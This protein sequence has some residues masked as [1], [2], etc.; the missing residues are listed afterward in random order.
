MISEFLKYEDGSILFGHQYHFGYNKDNTRYTG[1][2]K[3]TMLPVKGGEFVMGNNQQDYDETAKPEHRVV[4]DD[5]YIMERPVSSALQY[6]MLFQEYNFED[7]DNGATAEEIRASFSND[8]YGNI[9]ELE[10]FIIWLNKFYSTELDELCDGWRFRLPT[11]AEWEY[12]ARALG[13]RVPIQIYGDI[14]SNID[15][16]LSKIELNPS[17]IPYMDDYAVRNKI[18]L[19]DMIRYAD[20]LCMDVYESNFYSKFATQTI[21]NPLAIGTSSG[22]TFNNVIRGGDINAGRISCNEYYRKA[23]EYPAFTY[24]TRLVLANPHMQFNI[25]KD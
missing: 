6:E 24:S 1:Q 20:E 3:F 7:F 4:L 22:V 25:I 13:R 12:S 17:D 18:G 21:K 9:L 14:V 23:L 8:Q 15:E 5:F 2:G 19:C 16:Y 11:E 10:Q